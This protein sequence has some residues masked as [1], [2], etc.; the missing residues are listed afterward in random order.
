MAEI[1]IPSPKL[2][3]FWVYANI[4]ELAEIWENE[5]IPELASAWAQ[6]KNNEVME[7]SKRLD[8]EVLILDL[9]GD[10]K[11]IDT[12]LG[13]PITITHRETV[14]IDFKTAFNLLMVYYQGD[15]SKIFA[16]LTTCF[17]ISLTVNTIG[18]KIGLQNEL[19]AATTTKP[20]KPTFSFKKGK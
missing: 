15:Y 14:K 3:S 6:A 19:I 11:T 5:K 2:S 10:Q 13:I 1:K 17:N 9:I 4:P 8:I 18:K 20:A 7:A 16:A 12:P